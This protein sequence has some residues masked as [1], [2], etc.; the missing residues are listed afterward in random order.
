MSAV[1]VLEHAR[2]VLDKPENWCQGESAIDV[3]GNPCRL[4]DNNVKQWCMLSAIDDYSLPH[5]GVYYRFHRIAVDLCKEHVPGTFITAFNDA[6]ER[7]H[8]EVI[9]FLDKMIEKAKERGY[10]TD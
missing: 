7:T 5:R 3:D 10:E 2:K 6:P 1:S 8:G 4:K 9:G